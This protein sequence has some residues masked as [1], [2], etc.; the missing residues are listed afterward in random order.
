MLPLVATVW[1]A[2]Y[3]QISD[4][5]IVWSSN[6]FIYN[7]DQSSKYYKYWATKR[8]CMKAAGAT[9]TYPSA[10]Y[11]KMT[12]IGGGNTKEVKPVCYKLTE[13]STR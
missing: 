4:G 13:Y 8:D 11:Y 6:G 9:F 5:K 12:G 2:M 10:T 7:S 1:V 3:V